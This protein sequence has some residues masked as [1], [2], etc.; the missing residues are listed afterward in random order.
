VLARALADVSDKTKP[1]L[2]FIGYT[3]NERLARRTAAVYGD[4]IGLS[5]SRARR[6]M[7]LVAEDMQLEPGQ[8]EYEG[9]GYVHSDDVVNAGFVQGETSHV[10]VQVVYDE[11][12]ILDDY[13]G[14]DITRG[15]R[16]P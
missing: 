8:R 14:V 15:T 1:R 16:W 11:L 7:E 2:R 4:D 5:A 9:R 3:S 6:A 10:A 12:A 13:E